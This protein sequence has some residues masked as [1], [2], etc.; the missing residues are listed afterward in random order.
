M[1]TFAVIK[2]GGKQYKVSEG[3][4]LS[5]E[6]LDHKDGEVTFEEVLLVAKDDKVSIGTPTVSGAKVSAKVLADGKGKK[7][8]V[9]R[10]KSKV[11][12][13]KKKG[14]RQPFTQVEITKISA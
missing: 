5:I 13:K 3:D 8:L 14:H 2:T 9:F 7:K 12:Y 10:F 1:S 6:K 11:R 4:T